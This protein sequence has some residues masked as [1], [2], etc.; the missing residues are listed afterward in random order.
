MKNRIKTMLFVLL[1]SFAFTMYAQ[2]KQ[3]SGTITD[4][5]D[6]VPLPGASVS[7]KGTSKGVSSDF[8]GNFTISVGENDMLVISYVGYVS[9]EIPVAGKQSISVQLQSDQ[10]ALDEVVVVAYGTQTRES[11]TSSI[12]TVKSEELTDLTVSSPSAMLQGK[13]AGVQVSAS[14]GSPGSN[15]QILIRGMASLNGNVEPLWVV[16][17]VIQHGTPVVNPNDIETMSVLKDASATS[18]YGSRG[19]N[20]VII[21]T[22][23]QAKLGV[24]KLS[25]TSRTGFN[26]FTNGKFEVMN[27]QQ[28]YDYHAQ[29]GTTQEWYTPE[30]LERDFDWVKNATQTALVQ[31]YNVSYTTSTDKMRTFMSGGYY[32]EEGTIKG[33]EF[34]RYTFRMNLDYD[35]SKRLTLK[36][37][38]SFSFDDRYNAEHGRY[39]SYTNL[40]WDIPFDADGNPIKA[41]DS[42]EWIGRDQSN[43]YYDLQWNYGKSKT[44]NMSFN[45]DFEFKIL[46]NLSLISTNNFTLYHS[47]GMS[48][49]DPLSVGGT[50]DNGSLYN[51]SA[52]R[53]T[54]LTNQM[55]KY[56][57]EF[58]D[59]AITALAAYEYNDYMYEDMDATGIGL[60]GGGTILDV[61]SEPKSIGGY[62][63]E[64]AL[65]SAF[66]NVDY[67][68]SNRYYFKGSIRRD[69]A[70]NFG[71]ENQYGTFFSVGAGWNISNESFF[72]SDA[73]DLLKLRVSYGSVGNRPS[74]LYPYQGTYSA[75][76]HYD[77]IPAATLSQYGNP[78]LGWEKSYEANFALDMSFFNRLNVTAEYYNKDTSD[79]LY[80]V[81]LPAL[82]GFNGYWE[83][84]GGLKN[85]GF[86]V[87]IDGDVVR[88][89]DFNWNLGFNIGVNTNEI[90]ELFEGQ[91]QIPRG[92]KIFKVGE[93][94]NSWYMRKWA[95]VHPANGDPL[96]E[97][98]DS[99]TGDV[100]YTSNYNEA[101]EQLV[102]SATPDFIG[103]FSSNIAYKGFTLDARFS[104][105]SGGSIYNSSRELFDSDGLYP[106][107]NQQV[108]IDGWSRWE[109][110]G[111]NATHPRAIYG[112]NN[113]SNKPSS[114]YLEDRSYLK[115]KNVTLG[116]N[117]PTTILEKLQLSDARVYVAGDNLLTFTNYSGMDPEVGGINGDTSM[118]YPVPTRFVFGLNFSF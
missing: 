89:T 22:T 59:H 85:S 12:T 29:M 17:G 92:N 1:M 57:K 96:W 76:T 48:Y 53:F 24:S 51:S 30:L 19:A 93:D 95:G 7:V 5:N 43:Y 2:E 109:Q 61:T 44:F 84:V 37:K 82:T 49:A 10:S 118:S 6:G 50:A 28:L 26:E 45:G 105:V 80:Y 27:S 42:N 58:G 56:T 74:S 108:L 64:Y 70:S 21:V 68:Y 94:M 8:D 13:A 117:I 9:Q 102:G 115:L 101:T 4:A 69:G 72:N 78:D 111:D 16:D 83:N 38:M 87:A 116:Y 25:F 97:V 40:P 98:V 47:N 34:E 35:V 67:S 100:S 86:E 15:P 75:S 20:G 104:F 36:P 18:L 32:S 52:R 79:L 39:S 91:T 62:K 90:T 60:V 81:D 55:L 103:G 65:Q 41:Q 112:G 11:V 3:V 114:R 107:F 14:G 71:L 88:T 33:S 46:D 99:E 113:N 31:D 54:R 73:V 23:K 110:P 63:N 77:G 66:L 106:T